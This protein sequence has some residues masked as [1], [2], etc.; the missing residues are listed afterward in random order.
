ME[1]K[2]PLSTRC[3]ANVNHKTYRYTFATGIEQ[4]QCTRNAK[5]YKTETGWH[6]I[7][8]Q[9]CAQ[10]EL[11]RLKKYARRHPRLDVSTVSNEFY[12]QLRESIELDRTAGNAIQKHLDN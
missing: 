11:V 12:R 2:W 3:I 1:Q 9:L 4:R 8:T 6:I 5:K 10:H 7:S